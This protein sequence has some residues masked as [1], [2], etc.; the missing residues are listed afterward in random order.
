[1][2]LRIRDSNGNVQEIIALKGDSYRLT[3]TDKQEVVDL[4][5][6]KLSTET[7]TFTLEGG[8]VVTK[9]VVLK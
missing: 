3:E 5:T 6:A 9:T 1:M 2:I 7:W 8:S 4:V